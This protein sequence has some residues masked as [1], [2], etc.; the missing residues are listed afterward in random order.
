MRFRGIMPEHLLLA[1]WIKQ[2]RD[3]VGFNSRVV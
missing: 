2:Q 3:E 1:E